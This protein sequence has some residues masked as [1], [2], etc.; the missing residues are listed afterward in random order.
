MKI[1]IIYESGV[2][3][4]IKLSGD[5]LLLKQALSNITDNASKSY[6]TGTGETT[7]S[8]P[9]TGEMSRTFGTLPDDQL[10]LLFDAYGWYTGHKIEIDYIRLEKIE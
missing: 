7:Y 3:N 6:D 2:G 9:G 10:W 5:R 8:I 1:N 4:K